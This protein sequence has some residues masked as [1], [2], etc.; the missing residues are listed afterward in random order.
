MIKIRIDFKITNF[1]QGIIF[2]RGF[3]YDDEDIENLKK[4]ILENTRGYNFPIVYGVDIGH[5]DPML[6]IPLGVKVTIDSEKNLLS[7][8][9]RGV[10]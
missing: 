3:G 1:I 5:S 8:D 10:E 2:G 6:T 4:S 7:I 9:E